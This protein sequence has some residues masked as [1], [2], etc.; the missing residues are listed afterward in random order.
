MLGLI[1]LPHVEGEAESVTAIL[2]QCPIG[3]TIVGPDLSIRY[4]NAHFAQMVAADAV[5]GA[6][7]LLDHFLANEDD[8]VQVRAALA[9]G[10][11][12]ARRELRL[13]AEGGGSLWVLMS[14]EAVRFAAEPAMLVWLDDVTKRRR[15]VDALRAS[16]E[17]LDLAVSGTRSAIWEVD[18]S[19]HTTWWSKEFYRMLGYADDQH[20][21]AGEDVWERHVHPEDMTR[22][23]RA[24]HQYVHG[25]H[26]PHET[27]GEVALYEATYRLCRLDGSII[28][29]VA[30]GRRSLDEQG[31]PSRFNG[32]MLDVTAQKRAEQALRQAQQDLIQAEKMASL[33][34]L[35]AG[36]AHEINTPLGNTLTASSHLHDKV[37]DLATMLEEN[38][39]RRSDL[40]SFV[41]LLTETT[42]LMVTNCERAAELV[43]SFKQVAVDQT[44]GERRRF[45]LKG[46]IEEVLLS[47][48]PQL[49]KTGHRIAVECPEN[50][51]VDGYPGAISQLLT[52]FLLNSLMHAYDPGQTGNIVI[53]VKV[54]GGGLVELAY[55]DD[56]KGIPQDLLGRV[57]DP[58]F[59]TRRGNGGSGLG[60][61]IVYNLVTGTLRGQI[62]VESEPGHGTC[63]TVRFPLF[64]SDDAARLD[65]PND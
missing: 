26:Q 3:V 38:R 21:A 62:T 5:P 6:W 55:A 27:G 19:Q 20:P 35:V 56:G 37:N 52:N 47:L 39:L 25:E 9:S 64:L 59:T 53:R 50:L 57:Y 24:I 65:P 32:I 29:V 34:S 11:G 40:V 42:R 31:R 51:E 12:L 8:R 60:L 49:R 10:Q 33:G 2:E 13:T 43:Q 4:A 7:P 61:H 30:K 48:R 1:D 63:F 41:G 23:T 16:E 44:S 28:W 14:A 54:L 17:R 15:A 45:D 58:F 46:Y 22:V 18:F 36:V